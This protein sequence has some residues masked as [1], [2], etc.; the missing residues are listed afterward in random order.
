MFELAS[1]KDNNNTN[2][3]IPRTF[4]GYLR[5]NLDAGD[6]LERIYKRR[7]EPE[8]INIAVDEM[9]K[10][11]DELFKKDFLEIVKSKNGHLIF[12]IY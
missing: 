2:E 10:A 1:L 9:S 11:L 12:K 7:L 3:Y 4:L 8:R 5:N 6:T